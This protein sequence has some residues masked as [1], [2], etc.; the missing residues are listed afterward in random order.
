MMDDPG[1][2][3]D[4]AFLLPRESDMESFD[5]LDLLFLEVNNIAVDVH[6][7]LRLVSEHA[8][9]LFAGVGVKYW[10]ERENPA[11]SLSY[12]SVDWLEAAILRELIEI[13][14]QFAADPA[15]R[16]CQAAWRRHVVETGGTVRNWAKAHRQDGLP[17]D[18]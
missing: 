18:P 13:G 10:A 16:R 17:S 11:V 9:A 6:D 4:H 7:A 14:A 1:H 12:L 8:A 15:C 3:I 2:K 5:L